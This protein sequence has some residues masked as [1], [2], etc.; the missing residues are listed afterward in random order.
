MKKS[1][2][3]L[4]VGLFCSGIINAQDTLRMVA[5]KKSFF[6]FSVFP[7]LST[8]GK[9]AKYYSNDITLSLLVGMSYRE[10][11][12]ALAGLAN[13]I[14]ERA[15]GIQIAGLSN[16]VGD[17]GNGIM[18]S[19]LM[20]F[21]E[22]YNGF[23]AGG[24]SNVSENMRGI[25]I[26]GLGNI[27]NNMFGLQMAGLTNIA[28]TTKG[29]QF[30]GLGNITSMLQGTQVS[31][32]G[33]ISKD[34]EGLQLSGLMNFAEDVSGIQLAGLVNIANR[35]KGIQFAGLV[36]IADESDYPIGLINL[37]RNGEKSIGLTY[38]EA[39]SVTASFRS[40]GRI[41]YGILG[42][43]FNHRADDE[44]LVFEGGFGA[45]IPISARFRIN[46]EL[47]AQY[48]TSFSST[49]VNHYS[50][51]IQPA[52]RITP[53]LEIFAGPSI[54]YMTTDNLVND[55]MFPGNNIKKDFDNKNL[56][57]AYFGVSYGL[58]WIF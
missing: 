29:I 31:G 28:F 45:H 32:I 50:L 40:G 22:D 37:I 15:N 41:L 36:N 19:G 55:S 11:T 2:L 39:G 52:F 57:Q 54:N 38:N 35:V 47:K 30:G 25:Q 21:V 20:N 13:V 51:N 5:M 56:K 23:Q 46:N 24:L 27:S 42:L 12:F 26:G 10:N 6:H 17:S 49:S 16:I 44:P 1:I 48:M 3:L 34:M 58:Q 33:N 14:G 43:G 8:N 53:N 9:D 18:L 7:P 4:L